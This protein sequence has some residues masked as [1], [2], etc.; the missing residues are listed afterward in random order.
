MAG[1]VKVGTVPLGFEYYV[2]DMT[3]DRIDATQSAL[4]PFRGNAASESD[5]TTWNN[6]RRTAY[7]LG[8]FNIDVFG[9]MIDRDGS[10]QYVDMYGNHLST[11]M[12]VPTLSQI[13]IP[14]G[15]LSIQ[16]NRDKWNGPSI[17]HH[18]FGNFDIDMFGFLVEESKY[19]IDVDY[20]GYAS[21][22]PCL[23]PGLTMPL[24]PWGDIRNTT[25]R[26][27]WNDTLHEDKKRGNFDVDIF[28]FL[29]E[30]SRKHIDVDYNGY[31]VNKPVL[32]HQLT[33]MMIPWGD[34]SVEANRTTWNQ[35]L[36]EHKH[37]GNFD[38]DEY[39]YMV[40]EQSEKVYCDLMGGA[41]ET[42]QLAPGLKA[43]LKAKP[44]AGGTSTKSNTIYY[45]F[46]AVLIL[47]IIRKLIK[48]KTKV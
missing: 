24:S 43:P 40:M 14:W 15:D 41:V 23:A 31:P 2:Y 33:E 8:D 27:R 6:G 12:L 5:R 28:G 32:C 38:I 44:T 18:R 37:R 48:G 11:P 42:P 45:F 36:H 35:N 4:C 7:R 16:S 9:F 39:G 13:L 22:V 26:Q 17:G 19:H 29:V 34:L 1:G 46:A 3:P 21:S 47:L 20:F 10:N 30:E 25:D